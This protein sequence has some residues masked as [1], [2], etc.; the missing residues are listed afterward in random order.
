MSERLLTAK[1]VAELLA[2]PESW[3]REATRAGCL[4][5]VCLGRYR[6]YELTAIEAW[7][8]ERRS[9]PALTRQRLDISEQTSLE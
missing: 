5:H 7:L 3:V 1:E 2:V 8:V 6:R 9:G 4:P